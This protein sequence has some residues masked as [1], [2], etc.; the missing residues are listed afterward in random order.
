MQDGVFSVDIPGSGM[1]RIGAMDYNDVPRG[2]AS[3]RCD[4]P[5]FAREGGG[6]W[7]I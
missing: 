6:A 5:E 2:G 1:P 3:I 7:P 4:V